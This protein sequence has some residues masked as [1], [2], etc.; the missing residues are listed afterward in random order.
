MCA[1]GSESDTRQL[2]SEMLIVRLLRVANA[3][4][5]VEDRRADLLVRD[6][7]SSERVEAADM[8]GAAA[9]RAA[10]VQSAT[11]LMSRVTRNPL[12]SNGFLHL[13]AGSV[14]RR[15]GDVDVERE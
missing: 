1:Y 11:D 5:L 10:V 13:Q 9:T 2:E 4:K 14:A 3:L 15:V 6:A 8:T 12:L 7:S